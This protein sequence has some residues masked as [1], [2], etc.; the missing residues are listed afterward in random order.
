MERVRLQAQ[1]DA[2]QDAQ[3]GRFLIQQHSYSSHM[4][5]PEDRQGYQDWLDEHERRLNALGASVEWLEDDGSKCCGL[6]CGPSTP[7]EPDL[8]EVYQTEYIQAS[9]RLFDQELHTIRGTSTQLIRE[10]AMRASGFAGL[11]MSR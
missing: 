4:L 9:S 6:G 8:S 10:Q 5:F 11:G 2:K 7:S 1:E 3:E